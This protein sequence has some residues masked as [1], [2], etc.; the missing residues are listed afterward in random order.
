LQDNKGF[1]CLG[2]LQHKLTGTVMGYEE[3]KGMI[4]SFCYPG[5]D[6]HRQFRE[7][8]WVLVNEGLLSEMND[9]F[10]LPFSAIADFIEKEWV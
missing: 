6:F 7:L 5:E 2:V 9:D 4:H 1:C 8:N 10:R 3:H